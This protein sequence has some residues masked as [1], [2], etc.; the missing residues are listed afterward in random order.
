MAGEGRQIAGGRGEKQDWREGAQGGNAG[1][2]RQDQDGGVKRKSQ[3]ALLAPAVRQWEEK[4]LW[5]GSGGVLRKLFKNQLSGRSCV[6]LRK[7]PRDAQSRPALGHL[8]GSAGRPPAAAPPAGIP[9]AAPHAGVPGRRLLGPPPPLGLRAS[10]RVV[11]GE[12]GPG[13]RQ[14]GYSTWF[15]TPNCASTQPRGF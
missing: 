8:G 4:S 3:R 12:Q 15:F 1:E 9:P 11:L 7:Y 6:L 2:R 10:A 14:P 5:D 13:R